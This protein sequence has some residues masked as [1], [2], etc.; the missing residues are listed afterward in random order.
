MCCENKID[1]GAIK[2]KNKMNTESIQKWIMQ[3]MMSKPDKF[4]DQIKGL[5][6]VINAESVD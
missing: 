2:L 3:K 4:I 6:E 1:L 5:K